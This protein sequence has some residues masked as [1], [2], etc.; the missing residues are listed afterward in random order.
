MDN[1]NSKG[2][3]IALAVVA[4]LAGVL[5]GIVSASAFNMNDRPVTD[6]GNN[7][8]AE[9][10]V[11]ESDLRVTMNRLL[12]EHVDLAAP[13]LRNVF[14]E[15]ADTEASV[16]ALDE[17]SVELA[18]AIGSVYGEDAEESFLELWRQHV[19]FFADYV[20]AAREGDQAGMQ[21][22]E[23][24][25]AGYVEESSSFLS[26]ATALPKEALAEGLTE[27]VN[28]VV[29]IA[30]SYAAGNYEESYRVQREASQHIGMTADTLSDGIVDKF[31]EKF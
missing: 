8:Q 3:S 29:T 10:S 5:I 2:Q 14:D 24:D 17:N 7:N 11:A 18:A 26:E 6:M 25:L 15:S 9:S 22:A 31:P 12:T 23:K 21:Q 20:V 16:A 1:K 13:A 28:Q 27:H 30:N 4:L 19:G